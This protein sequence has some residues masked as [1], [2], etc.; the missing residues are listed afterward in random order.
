MFKALSNPTRLALFLRLVSCC[1]PGRRARTPRG[2]GAPA[3]LCVGDLGA[4][5]RAVPS[6][7][8]HHLKELREAGLVRMERRG[9]LVECRVDGEALS[10]L[11]RFLREAAAG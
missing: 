9:Q 2:A 11:A 1:P 7:I 10:R 6:T 4:G 5:I 3:C 8:S